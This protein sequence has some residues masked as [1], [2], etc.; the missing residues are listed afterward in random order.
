MMEVRLNTHGDDKLSTLTMIADEKGFSVA[1]VLVMGKRDCVLIDCQWTRSNIYRVIA[2]IAETNL[3]LKAVFC[4]HAHPDHYWGVGYVAEAFPE[5]TLYAMPEDIEVIKRQFFDKTEHWESVIG[6]VNLCRKLPELTPLPD[7]C[8]IELE[9]ETIEVLPK[10]WGDLK[11][12][13]AVWI[14]SIKTLIG[15][16]ILFSNAHPFTCEVSAKGRAKWIADIEK[17]EQ[18]GAEVVIPGHAKAGEPFDG[19]SFKFTKD[20]LI[21]TEEELAAT[22]DMKEFFYNMCMR[23]PTANLIFL[24]NDMNSSVFL[25]G[26]EWNWSDMDDD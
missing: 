18:F 8:T 12:N 23:F 19:R 21:A 24:S 5:A 3:N 17:L 10:L 1:S 6:K 16:D 2:E 26:R 15:S 14:P 13:T 20:Y 4:S 25:G 11:Y 22:Q 9:G 7:D